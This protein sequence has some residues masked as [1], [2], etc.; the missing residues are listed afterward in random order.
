MRQ[1]AIWVTDLVPLPNVNKFV[2]ASTEN[3]LSQCVCVCVC[4]R[5][6]VSDLSPTPVCYDLSAASDPQ[7]VITGFPHSVVA[8]DYWWVCGVVCYVVYW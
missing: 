5:V 3:V 7:Q 1:K 8:M 4:V 6:H 2:A